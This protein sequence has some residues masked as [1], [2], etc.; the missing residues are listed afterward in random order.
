MVSLQELNDGIV[1]EKFYLNPVCGTITCDTV[2]ATNIP[3]AATIA[4]LQDKTQN[5]SA[6]GTIAGTTALS[7]ALKFGTNWT[8][9]ENG[10][11]LDITNVVSGLQFFS[12]RQ[13]GFTNSHGAGTG[14]VG[15][16][17]RQSLG[18]IAAPTATQN[19]N[20]ITGLFFNGHNGTG[21]VQ[22]AALVVLATQNYAVGATGSKLQLQIT[23]N[24]TTG[25]K[26]FLEANETNLIIGNSTTGSTFYTLPMTR[27][28]TGQG[29][30]SDGSGALT[31][32]NILGGYYAQTNTI[33]VAN[34]TT[35]TTLVGTGAGSLTQ[36]AN[37]FIVGQSCVLD[38]GGV[39]S[40]LNNE[41]LTIRIYCGVSGLTL[42]G[43]VPTLTIP[44][45]TGKWWGIAVYFTVRQIGAA[46]VAQLSLRAVYQQNVDTGNNLFGSS[47]HTVNTTTFDT[48]IIN[49]LRITA[50]W[51]TASASN[52][53]AM[54]QLVLNRSF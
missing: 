34:T 45:S 38:G 3:S 23:P 18:T 35:E 25:R 50:Q 6:A 28:T 46:G 10:T 43:T 20:Q 9:A 11:A 53:I 14:A 12:F 7:G 5:I 49:T 21:Y 52:T 24:S 19:T 42:L 39:M 13:G 29:L 17:Y 32:Q 40:C 33:T 16:E 30:V 54:A 1:A 22:T 8:V 37:S 44:T 51:G 48:T 41:Q 47:F 36:P 4:D 15:C 27:G 2:F 31:F 26:T